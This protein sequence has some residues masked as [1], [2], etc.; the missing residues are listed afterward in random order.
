MVATLRKLDPGAMGETDRCNACQRAK[1]RQWQRL[2][3]WAAVSREGG[4]TEGRCNG[5]GGNGLLG[6]QFG[7]RHVGAKSVWGGGVTQTHRLN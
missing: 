5:N 6:A 1:R 4:G 7:D 3:V 2:L